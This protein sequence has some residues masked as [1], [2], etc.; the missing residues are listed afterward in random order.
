MTAGIHIAN[1]LALSSAAGLLMLVCGST[2]RM[3]TW[4]PPA[5]PRAPARA[6]SLGSH[7]DGRT[8]AAGDPRASHGRA[9]R[10]L[11]VGSVSPCER[12][13]AGRPRRAQRTMAARARARAGRPGRDLALRTE[14]EHPRL[15]AQPVDATPGA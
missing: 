6:A 4:K 15:A 2:K 14:R 7:A 13:L 3:L 10:E 11:A 12:S 1:T 5:R 9:P 8:C